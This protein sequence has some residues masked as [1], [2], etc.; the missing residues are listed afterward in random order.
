MI[1]LLQINVNRSRRAHDLL[2]MAALETNVSMLL[3]SAPNKSVI[4]APPWYIDA[5]EDTAIRILSWD[6][7]VIDGFRP[8]FHMVT[9]G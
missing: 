7:S 3:I 2:H 6:I 9:N 4:E 8:G 1:Q 5:R